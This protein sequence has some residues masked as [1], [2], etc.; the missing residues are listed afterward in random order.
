MD[1]FLCNKIIARQRPEYQQISR[2]TK[3]NFHTARIRS[4]DFSYFNHNKAVGVTPKNILQILT[5]LYVLALASR[6]PSK[7]SGF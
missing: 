4:H 5:R 6:T 1:F 3:T 7:G 2:K